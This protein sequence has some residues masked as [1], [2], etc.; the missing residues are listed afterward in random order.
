M[1]LYIYIYI[2]T[3]PHNLIKGETLVKDIFAS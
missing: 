2:C 1:V 3:K